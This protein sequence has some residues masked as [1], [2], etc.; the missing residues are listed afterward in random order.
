MERNLF[1]LLWNVKLLLIGH[2]GD[3]KKKQ[4]NTTN[5]SLDKFEKMAGETGMIK[6]NQKRANI[7]DD[8]RQEAVDNRDYSH[9]ERI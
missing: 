5:S 7:M 4:R 8:K 6:S 2:I 1:L 9:L 3:I